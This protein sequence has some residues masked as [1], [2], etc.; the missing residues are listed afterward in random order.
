MNQT[1]FEIEFSIEVQFHCDGITQ[2]EIDLLIE[3]ASY[4]SDYE[5]K[6]YYD[7][8]IKIMKAYH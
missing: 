2:Q 1:Q 5:R 3:Q 4:M 8:L 7:A 6:I